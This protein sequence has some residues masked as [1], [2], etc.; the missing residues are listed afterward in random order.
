MNKRGMR[1]WSILRRTLREVGEEGLNGTSPRGSS[2]LGFGEA[3]D[4]GGLRRGWDASDMSGLGW[5]CFDWR[6]GVVNL[7]HILV[8]RGE[9]LVG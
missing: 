5:G 1:R 7:A 2:S 9:V 3:G 4:D 8:L 6:C